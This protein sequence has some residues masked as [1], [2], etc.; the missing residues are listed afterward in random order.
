MIASA[1][2]STTVPSASSQRAC[3]AVDPESEIYAIVTQMRDWC[4]AEPDDWRSIRRHIRDRFTRHGG[5]AMRDKNGYELNTAATIAALLLGRGEFATTLRLAFNFGW[6]A[7]NNAATCGTILG[8][9]RGLRWMDAQRW[10]IRDRYANRTRDAMPDDE[11]I[12]RFGD[13]LL[14]LARQAIREQGGSV[15]GATARIVI[16]RPSNVEALPRPLDRREAFARSS[17]R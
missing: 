11:T 4:H 8:V 5:D 1:Y 2:S 10:N 16:E 14:A 15:E 13:R 17:C 9:V 6:D 3:A 12:T 7:D